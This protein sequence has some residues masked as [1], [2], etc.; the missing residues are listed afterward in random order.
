MKNLRYFVLFIACLGGIE[1]R[2]APIDETEETKET[3]ESKDYSEDISDLRSKNESQDQDIKG[4][5]EEVEET[6]E[7]V[8]KIKRQIGD[9]DETEMQRRFTNMENNIKNLESKIKT[10][11]GTGGGSS[12]L[13]SSVN[14]G[15][16][17]IANLSGTALSIGSNIL[18][19]G[20]SMLSVGSNIVSNWKSSGKESEQSNLP[21]TLTPELYTPEFLQKIQTDVREGKEPEIPDFVSEKDKK[22][23]EELKRGAES[24]ADPQTME[25]YVSGIFQ[26]ENEEQKQ[27][28]KE[29]MAQMVEDAKNLHED[30]TSPEFWARVVDAVRNKKSFTPPEDFSDNDKKF[31]ELGKEM[32]E[33]GANVSDIV[34][35]MK[36][37]QKGELMMGVSPI[38][39]QDTSIGQ[40]VADGIERTVSQAQKQVGDTVQST[41]SGIG[42][43]I[44]AAASQLQQQA[45]SVEQDIRGA[46][47][48]V[49]QQASDAVQ[50][51]G[52][53]VSQAQKQVGDMVQST[54]SGVTKGIREVGSQVQQQAS[55][56][57]QDI[58]AAVSQVQQQ[59]DN[60][61]QGIGAAASQVQ[62]QASSVAQDIRGAVSQTQKQVGDMVQSTTSGVTKGIR[63]VG[64]QVQQQASSVAQKATR[65]LGGF[66]SGLEK[67]IQSLTPNATREEKNII[68]TD[69]QGIRYKVSQ[70]EFF[71]IAPQRVP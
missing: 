53:A 43:G 27:L 59:V 9:F 7:G 67:G 60:A 16:S 54:T 37:I 11:S 52:A 42:S 57:A 66:F 8:E 38:K 30:L 61:V 22:I 31:L 34:R 24:G 70:K 10:G 23:I 3:G 46:V 6:R 18:S 12:S 19:A 2:A 56:V 69:S 48:Q 1:L 15:L 21:P 20:G 35:E 29:N 51:I 41:T 32:A 63:E 39:L 14:E 36:N 62:Q 68:L 65:G 5:R 25:S 40:S 28:E 49:Q 47:S 33:G 26:K 58:G 50:G 44:G 55:S 13:F 45:S 71:N 4:V 17:N 64:S